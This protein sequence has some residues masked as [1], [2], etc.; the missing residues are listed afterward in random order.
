MEEG[1]IGFS[2][3][4]FR[5]RHK[6]VWT[7]WNLKNSHY[8]GVFRVSKLEIFSNS[9]RSWCLYVCV[10]HVCACTGVGWGW[11]RKYA[12]GNQR[13]IFGMAPQKP[14]TTFFFLSF[15]KGF[16]LASRP[17]RMASKSQRFACLCLSS[18]RVISVYHKDWV[19]LLWVLVI[20]GHS[21]SSRDGDILAQR[22]I[23][24]GAGGLEETK[25]S[26]FTFSKPYFWVQIVLFNYS[27]A[28]GSGKFLIHL[29]GTTRQFLFFFINGIKPNKTLTRLP[30]C[31]SDPE[32]MLPFFPFISNQL[33]DYFYHP[34][35]MLRMS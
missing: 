17:S 32:G 4:I 26:A 34:V 12:Y 8:A 27:I 24:Y 14:N 29:W 31:L 23:L 10:I 28:A 5:V 19:F 21:W 2:V 20:D 22:T 15:L 33:S 30:R 6:D 7:S 35:H 16:E 18:A 9:F 11:G 13:T 1:P 3:C 25:V